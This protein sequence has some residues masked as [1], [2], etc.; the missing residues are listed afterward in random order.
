MPTVQFASSDTVD[1]RISAAFTTGVVKV[2][3]YILEED[4]S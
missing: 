4:R 1:L 3:A 2:V